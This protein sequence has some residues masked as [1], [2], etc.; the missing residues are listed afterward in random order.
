MNKLKNY[1]NK[2]KLRGEMMKCFK[3]GG[4]YKEVKSGTK[5]FTQ[6]PKIHD[7]SIDYEQE[8]VRFV[9]TIPTGMNP[10][11]I[12]KQ[13]WVFNQTFGEYIEITGKYKKFFIT[14]YSKGIP[15]VV[16]YRFE[17]VHPHMNGKHLPVVVGYDMRNNLNVLDLKDLHHIL[18][19]GSTGS[20]KSSLFRAM[21]VSLILQ[22]NPGDI[23]LILG[24][25]KQSEFGIYR[26]IPHVKSLHMTQETLFVELQ[27]VEKEMTRRGKLLDKH[28]IEHVSELKEKLPTIMI[29]IDE[30]ITLTD[31]KKIMKILTNISCLGRSASIHIIGAMQSG[32]AKDLGGQFLNNMNCRISGKQSD[33]TNAKVSGFNSTK[34]ITVAG[35]MV[36]MIEGEE[37]QIQVP[38]IDK[39]HAKKVLTPYKIKSVE[40]KQEKQDK[41][42]GENVAVNE[43]ILEE[44]EE[45]E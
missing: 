24:D 14:L 10:E 27:R 31:N 12:T 40:L 32:R 30:I 21:L 1:L 34:D 29:V 6:Y 18:V 3:L 33:A 28:D 8:T 39:Q 23:E 26:N 17:E 35:R 38:F 7:I 37:T 43:F 9:F 2:M 41:K 4:I 13:E 11:L 42:K 15:K 45:D 5:T 19:T 44:G 36:L 16:K 25:M 20:G 22:Q